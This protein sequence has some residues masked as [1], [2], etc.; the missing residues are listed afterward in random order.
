MENIIVFVA[1]AIELDKWSIALIA[2]SVSKD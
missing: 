1:M 2:K